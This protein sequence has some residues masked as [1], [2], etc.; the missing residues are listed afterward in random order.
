MRTN[1]AAD[2]ILQRR[3]DLAASRVVFGIRSK[4]QQQIERQSDRIAL[5][6]H[7][8]FLHDVEKTYLNASGQ[9]GQFVDG[10][11]AAISARNEA[12]VNRQL[13]GKILAAARGFDR[14]DIADHI[15]NRYIR[16]RELLNVAVFCP[17]PC[18][19]RLVALLGHQRA[20]DSGRQ[21]GR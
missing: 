5:N 20:A 10:E 9:I 19:R 2:A 15:R 16:G 13:V 6:L 3:N 14:I 11:N 8:A 21:I 18:D 12:V 4:D 7:V 1:L 17:D